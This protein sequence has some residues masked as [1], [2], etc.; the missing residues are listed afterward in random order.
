MRNLLSS[1]HTKDNVN[2]NILVGFSVVCGTP[3][4][5]CL[6]R[7]PT[8]KRPP[9]WPFSWENKCIVYISLAI[10]GSINFPCHHEAK[11]EK[12]DDD[13]IPAPVV[14]SSHRCRAG[15]GRVLP[16]LPSDSCWASWTHTEAP[17][18]GRTDAASAPSGLQER[19]G[20]RRLSFKVSQQAL[21]LQTHLSLSLSQTILSINIRKMKRK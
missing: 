7:N 4:W 6:Y 5:R 17:P 14:W 9:A 20:P 11:I 15:R 3:Y 21:R 2:S 13:S 10:D 12:I 18:S 8:L 1:H 19:E 16:P